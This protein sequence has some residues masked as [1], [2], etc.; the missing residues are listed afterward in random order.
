MDVRELQKLLA[1]NTE[2]ARRVSKILPRAPL[3][4]PEQTARLI[5]A[6]AERNAA[7]LIMRDAMLS[8]LDETRDEARASAKRERWILIAAVGSFLATVAL[9]LLEVL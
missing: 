9:L 3:I 7:P 4:D 8:L 2:T 6:Q 1:A 5:A